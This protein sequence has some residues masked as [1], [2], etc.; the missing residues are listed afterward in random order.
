MQQTLEKN[1]VKASMRQ[2]WEPP[3]SESALGIKSK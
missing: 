3:D 2:E 1:E